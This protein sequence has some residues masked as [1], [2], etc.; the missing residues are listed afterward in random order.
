MACGMSYSTKPGK[1]VVKHCFE[2]NVFHMS[3]L[4]GRKG[5]GG[6][7]LGVGERGAKLRLFAH[8][9]MAAISLPL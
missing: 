1:P 8:S 6:R 9:L 3:K 2:K 5:G 7:G 4:Q